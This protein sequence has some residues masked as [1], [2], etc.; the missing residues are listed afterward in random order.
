MVLKGLTFARVSQVSEYTSK[1]S[2][3]LGWGF[4]IAVHR[5][6][7]CNFSYRVFQ[8]FDKCLCTLARSFKRSSSSPPT[9]L[10]SLAKAAHTLCKSVTP[11]IAQFWNVVAFRRCSHVEV[12]KAV[13]RKRNVMLQTI[14][15]VRAYHFCRLF[16]HTD[17]LRLQAHGQQGGNFYG[18]R[19]TYSFH[20]A[21]LR[22]QSYISV[23]LISVGSCASRSQA[24]SL[25]PDLV[26][27]Q[28]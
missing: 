7:E 22:V 25:A 4:G 3:N 9:P 11:C 28:H 27:S 12:R 23:L 10:C 19:N 24:D 5:P 14:L 16:I 20:N 26:D 6:G 21:S 2:D 18:K 1:R 15:H 13:A 8:A 17:L